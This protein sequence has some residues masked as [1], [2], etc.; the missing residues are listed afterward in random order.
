MTTAKARVVAK[1]IQV[2]STHATIPFHVQDGPDKGTVVIWEA[3]ISD[4]SL[5]DTVNNLVVCGCTAPNDG[6]NLTGVD[7]NVVQVTYGA[8]K[9]V[10]SIAE[11]SLFFAKSKKEELAVKV[12]GAIRNLGPR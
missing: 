4:T 2:S 5:S 8:D 10:T 7:R 12:A 3:P 6:L 1:G 11:R 9:R